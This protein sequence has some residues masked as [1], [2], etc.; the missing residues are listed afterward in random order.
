RYARLHGH[1][2]AVRLQKAMNETVGEVVR[3]AA[4]EGIDADV[5]QGGVL[6]VAHTPAQLARLKEFHSAEIAFG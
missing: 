6:E 4:A 5:H 2:A 3:A 1:E